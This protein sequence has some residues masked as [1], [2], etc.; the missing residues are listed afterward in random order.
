MRR[1]ETAA[2][3]KVLSR[4]MTKFESNLNQDT[5]HGGEEIAGEKSGDH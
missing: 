4:L 1:S 5:N 2:T 3:R